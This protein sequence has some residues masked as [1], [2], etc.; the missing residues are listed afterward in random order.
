MR[1]VCLIP[2]LLANQAFFAFATFVRPFVVQ[3][4]NTFDVGDGFCK[5]P[6]LPPKAYLDDATFNGICLGR[7]ARFL[8]IPFAQPP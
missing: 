7:T 4:Q 3:D 5:G 6:R 1:F 8:G 2:T